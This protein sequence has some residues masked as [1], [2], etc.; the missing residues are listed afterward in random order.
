MTHTEPNTL[1]DTIYAAVHL[2]DGGATFDVFAVA[3]TLL[4][5]WS[6]ATD[7]A[8]PALAGQLLAHGYLPTGPEQLATPYLVRIPL[9][10]C[11]S[12]STALPPSAAGGD[13]RCGLC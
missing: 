7:H 6:D 9:A 10:T 1:P 2:R 11:A 5:T 3:G 12:C 8:A 13:G 4:D